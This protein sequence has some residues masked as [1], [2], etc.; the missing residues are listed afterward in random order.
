MEIRWRLEAWGILVVLIKV[1]KDKA[2][3]RASRLER[4]GNALYL[5]NDVEHHVI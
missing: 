3:E 5:I 2:K 1:K 4:Q